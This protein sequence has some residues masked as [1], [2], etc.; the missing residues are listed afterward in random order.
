M[1]VCYERRCQI[2]NYSRCSSAVQSFRNGAF[3]R[4]EAACLD[5]SVAVCALARKLAVPIQRMLHHGR[6]S[7][8]IGA[9]AFESHLRYQRLASLGTAGR[10]PGH[11]LVEPTAPAG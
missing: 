3:M 9:P 5:D 4:H 11:K 7:V 8:D 1:L 2:E 10:S 6:S